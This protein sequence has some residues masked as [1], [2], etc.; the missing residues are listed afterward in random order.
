MDKWGNKLSFSKICQDAI[1][2]E[3]QKREFC[4][5]QLGEKRSLKEI[6][7]NGNLE[8][9][10]GQYAVGKEMGFVYAMTSPYPEIKAYEKYAK[11]WDLQDPEVLERF[12]YALD[13]ISILDR[14][15]LRGNEDFSD[16]S[17][18][19]DDAVPLTFSFDRGFM[20]GVI[21]FIRGMYAGAEAPKL[22]LE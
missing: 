22:A 8:T 12:Q 9:S 10:E 15:A 5:T 11:N 2:N 21:D 19:P 16:I 20:E 13:V 4:E 18:L 14:N 3:M 6:F 1:S 7:E 17:E